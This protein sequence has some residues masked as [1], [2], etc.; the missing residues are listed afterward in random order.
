[1]NDAMSEPE[2]ARSEDAVASPVAVP[3]VPTAAPGTELPSPARTPQRPG[4]MRSVLEHASPGERR[5]LVL[6]MQRSVG[7]AV[8]TRYLSGTPRPAPAAP[9]PVMRAVGPSVM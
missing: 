1:M 8:V 5:K 2:R 4:G 3:E 6:G 7:N 9:A